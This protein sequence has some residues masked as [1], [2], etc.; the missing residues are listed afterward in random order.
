M[1]NH[2]TVEKE[3]PL[4]TQEWLKDQVERGMLVGP[5]CRKEIPWR[6][7]TTHPLH[8]VVKDEQLCVD[9]SFVQPGTPSGLNQGIPK[10][11]YKG[12][13]FRYNLPSIRDFVNDATEISLTDVMG[14]KIDW[15]H[16]Y[17][18]NSLDPGEW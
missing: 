3:Y 10:E 2:P 8:S 13:T 14:F 6:N 18:Q 15:S 5:I 9:A 12:A 11:E 7:L 16:A 4:Q 1:P 17:R